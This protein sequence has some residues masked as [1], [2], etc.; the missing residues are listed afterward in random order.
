MRCSSYERATEANLSLQVLFP[1][2]YGIKTSI[3]FRKK[4]I[5]LQYEDPKANSPILSE[6]YPNG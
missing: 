1:K 4:A 6:H 2:S 3:S 5:D